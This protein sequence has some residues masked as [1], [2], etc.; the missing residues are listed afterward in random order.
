MGRRELQCSG[1]R[2]GHALCRHG[3]VQNAPCFGARLNIT[4]MCQNEDVCARFFATTGGKPGITFMKPA[5]REG[6]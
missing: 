2:A 3:F 6:E 4:P 5:Q 1:A